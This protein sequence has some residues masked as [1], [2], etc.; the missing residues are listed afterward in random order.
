L[1][2]Q[3]GHDQV[4]VAVAVEIAPRSR[5]ARK[6]GKQYA[7][8]NKSAARIPIQ[9][10]NRHIPSAEPGHQHIEVSVVIVVADGDAGKRRLRHAGSDLGELPHDELK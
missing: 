3:S 9:G 1:F 10:R 4:E 6:A 5:R 8:I 7:A 2:V